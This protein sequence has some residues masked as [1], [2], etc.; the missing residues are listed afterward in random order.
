MDDV[1]AILEE[2]RETHGNFQTHAEISQKLKDCMRKHMRRHSV[3]YDD[4][5]H[6]QAEA[7]D[8]IQHKIARILNGNPNEPDHWLDIAG[9]A[10][11]VHD[12]L[13]NER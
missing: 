12:R 2:R 9:Y 7:L 6:D 10:K 3:G 13:K 4:L 8:M 1:D 11:L 5:D